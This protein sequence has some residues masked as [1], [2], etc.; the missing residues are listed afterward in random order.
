MPQDHQLGFS[1]SDGTQYLVMA[2]SHSY[3]MARP[4]SDIDVRGWAIPPKEYF[5][6]YHK[7][8][9][10]TEQRWTHKNFPWM[11]QLKW[12]LGEGIVYAHQD[13]PID[14]CIYGIQKFVKLAANCNPNII[15]LLFVEDED[16]LYMSE[17]G[18][19]LRRHRD[20]FLTSR[21]FYTFTGYAVAQL[22]RINTHRRWLINP[23]TSQPVRRDHGLPDRTVIPADQR[24]AADKL[25]EKQVR[26]WLLEE[27][28]I[29]ST[30][31]QTI[32]ED[33]A[34]AVASVTAGQSF[35]E[36]V[37]QAAGER[38]GMSENFI[39]ILQREKRY[40]QAKTEWS[41]YQGWLKNR[42]PARAELEARYGYDTKHASHL[43]RLLIQATDILVK[44]TL[45]IKDPGR[46]KFL[47]E[48]RSGAWT[49]DEL[50]AWADQAMNALEELYKRDDCPVPK[51]PD[52]NK[53]DELMMDIIREDFGEDGMRNWE[54]R[55][56]CE[57][58]NALGRWEHAQGAAKYRKIP[59]K[60]ERF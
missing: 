52:V 36:S 29:D 40:K 5:L 15:E 21:A 43:I 57:I 59:G 39:D 13:E 56:A 12:R 3:G 41:Q 11:E 55:K 10:Q 4:E 54:Y 31:V 30:L 48:I 34:E 23:P 53:I 9:E 19:A 1:I 42:N 7:H 8:F 22:K 49:Y 51:K 20:L 16:I 46:A 25:I 2:G 17:L 50:I 27:A 37:R 47:F 45:T 26:L 44:G 38:L 33:I 24:E 28:D 32:Q 18:A 6:S 60:A 14:C 35:R 58:A